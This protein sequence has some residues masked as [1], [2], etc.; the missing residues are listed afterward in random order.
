MTRGA[1]GESKADGQSGIN[2]MH[3][4]GGKLAHALLEAALVEGAHL[5]QKNNGILHQTAAA[6]FERDVGGEGCLALLAGDG[7]CDYGGTVF[8]ANVILDDEHGAHTA[9]FRAYDGA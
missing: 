4:V 5:L 9:L 7:G 6:R 1:R 3:G 2:G 8:V